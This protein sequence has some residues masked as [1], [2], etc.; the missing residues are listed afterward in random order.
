MITLRKCWNG[1]DEEK[2]WLPP[3]GNVTPAEQEE[4]GSDLQDDWMRIW[5][6]NYQRLF[7]EH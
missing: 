1:Y 3:G 4:R 6:E 2:P 7:L 5:L